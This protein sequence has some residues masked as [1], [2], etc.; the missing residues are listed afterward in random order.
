MALERPVL[1]PR[2]CVRCGRC[3]EIC[4][5]RAI[6]LEVSGEAQGARNGAPSLPRFDLDSCI[7]CYCC[8]EIC[9]EG[10]IRKSDPPLVGRLMRLFS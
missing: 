6:S 2:K 9:P 1:D 4:A 10:A 5:S 7:R 3:V 8:A